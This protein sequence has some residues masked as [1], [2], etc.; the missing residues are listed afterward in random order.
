MRTNKRTPR[1]T[2]DGRVSYARSYVPTPAANGADQNQLLGVSYARS[3]VPTR[4]SHNES[5]PGAP[6][7]PPADPPSKNECPWS[8][9]K[10]KMY[11]LAFIIQT[12]LI[13]V[14]IGLIVSA[15]RMAFD[16]LPRYD[17]DLLWDNAL[18]TSGAPGASGIPSIDRGVYPDVPVEGV[19]Q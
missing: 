17:P 12:V 19:P 10:V 9:R 3:Y 4:L 5:P 14:A 2:S 18:E 13:G 16:D 15:L 6:Q 11:L 8:T 7:R 1:K